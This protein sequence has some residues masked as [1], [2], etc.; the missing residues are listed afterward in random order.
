MAA[1][2]VA[3]NPAPRH[4]FDSIVEVVRHASP[5]IVDQHFFSVNCTADVGRAARCC[6]QKD[7][8]ARLFE[9][10]RN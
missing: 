4:G 5:I 9:A 8:V 3:D 10:F 7:I 1:G 2:F 6:L